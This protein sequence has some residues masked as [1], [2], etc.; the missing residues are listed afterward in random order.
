M[1]FKRRHDSWKRFDE[2]LVARENRLHLLFS[3]KFGLLERFVKALN[4]DGKYFKYYSSKFPKIS[5]EK[6]VGSS[7][8][9]TL[10]EKCSRLESH[11]KE[12]FQVTSV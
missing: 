8:E 2:A 12:N 3:I 4:R 5:A 9:A 10:L 7:G 11:I 1:I 6:L